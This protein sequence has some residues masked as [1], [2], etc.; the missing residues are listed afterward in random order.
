MVDTYMNSI[1]SFRRRSAIVI[2]PIANMVASRCGDGEQLLV[3]DE[4]QLSVAYSILHWLPTF[5]R[6]IRSRRLSAL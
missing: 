4:D 5:R 2:T 6:N 1:P 3:P